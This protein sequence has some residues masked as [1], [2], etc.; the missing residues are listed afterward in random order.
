M[1]DGSRDNNRSTTELL[2]E[3][4]SLLSPEAAAA[5]RATVA[6]DLKA[7][8]D[9]AQ[10]EA[11]RLAREL[12]ELASGGEVTAPPPEAPIPAAP[13]APT[14]AP[15][16]QAPTAPTPMM[17]L[18]PPDSSARTLVLFYAKHYPGSKSGDFVAFA[19]RLRPNL[20]PKNIHH[21]L[22]AQSKD[23]H[24]LVKLGDRPHS[25]Y[26]PSD[27]PEVKNQGK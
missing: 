24:P 4:E 16:V 19:E 8:R 2:R 14:P 1:A 3:V 11:E 23:G 17:E 7:R 20:D 5:V 25:R 9:R 13:V 22:Y 26:Y 18:P 15:K 21:E 27:H 10:A 12:D 6:A